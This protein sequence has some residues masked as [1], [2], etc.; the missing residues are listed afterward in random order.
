MATAYPRTA[1]IKNKG[2]CAT[3]RRTP[4]LSVVQSSDG[5]ADTRIEIL[6]CERS[7]R[8]EVD[9]DHGRKN[10]DKFK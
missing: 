4:S 1:T 2:Y 5:S 6:I 8:G 3:G 10:N 9:E 7:L